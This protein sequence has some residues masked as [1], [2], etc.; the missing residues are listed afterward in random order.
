MRSPRIAIPEIHQDVKNYVS[1]VRGAGM[2]PVVVSAVKEPVRAQ[3]R[4]RYPDYAGVQV[5]M[6]FQAEDFDG[7]LLPGGGDINPVRFGQE[8]QGSIAIS[9]ELDELQFAMLDRFVK[10]QKPVLG[11][12]RGHQLINVYFG[13]TLIQHLPGSFRHAREGNGPDKVHSVIAGEE[14]WLAK[15]YGT[16]FFHNSAHHQA[17]DRAGSGLV[18]DSYCPEDSTVES[19]HHA[20]LPIYGVQWHPERM[21]LEHRRDDT[22]NGLPVFLFF[23]RHVL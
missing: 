8:N 16:K 14:S 15:L 17:V 2:E 1:A 22:V 13:G 19:L 7:L 12:C 20:E 9:D 23:G 4:Q 21:C 3:S 10:C 6:E 5:H 18:F 11:I